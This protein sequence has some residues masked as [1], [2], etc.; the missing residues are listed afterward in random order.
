MDERERRLDGGAVDGHEPSSSSASGLRQA[1][2]SESTSMIVTGLDGVIQQVTTA[3]NLLPAD[4]DQVFLGEQIVLPFAPAEHAFLQSLLEKTRLGRYVAA[5]SFPVRLRGAED[6]TVHLSVSEITGTPS[7]HRLLAWHLSTA[8]HLLAA[9]R[10]ETE[11]SADRNTE[12]LAA[13]QRSAERTQRALAAARDTNRNLSRS[14]KSA[15]E[16]SGH[17]AAMFQESSKTKDELVQRV[18][19]AWTTAVDARRSVEKA[20]RQLEFLMEVNLTLGQ[21][22]DVSTTLRG[23]AGIVV[24]RISDCCVVHLL[25]DDRNI[26]RRAVVA[27]RDPSDADRMNALPEDDAGKNDDANALYRALRTSGSIVVHDLG[28]AAGTANVLAW[29]HELGVT[30]CIVTALRSQHRVLGAMTFASTDR[31]RNYLPEDLLMAEAIAFSSGQALDNALLYQRA[32]E[33][34]R[35]RERYLSMASHELR[36]PLTVVSGFGSLILRQIA[37]DEPDLERIRMLGYEL[38]RGVERLEMLTDGLLVSASTQETLTENTFSR[39]DLTSMVEEL[40]NSVNATPELVDRHTITFDA[41]QTVI[42]TGDAES[43]ERALFNIISNALKYSP[44][45]STVHVSVSSDGAAATIRVRDEG[46]GMT[47]EEQAELFSPFMRGRAAR[48]T[49]QGSGLGLYITKQIVEQHRGEIEVES[50]PGAGSTFTIHLPLTLGKT[51]DPNL[52]E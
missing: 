42:I 36:S 1:I 48:E 8:G 17:Q 44:R 4:A 39:M 24:P 40:L 16:L 26:L 23:I 35:I 32:E 12:T 47:D 15:R 25:D 22:L 37:A 11:V 10:G 33:A 20:V 28:T 18:R 41:P 13:R 30:S 34:S 45:G 31:S 29:H 7:G 43:L 6:A 27:C 52:M 51:S 3:G 50:Q 21:S 2:H 46:I 5:G 9:I 38:Q 19:E 14:L 49:A